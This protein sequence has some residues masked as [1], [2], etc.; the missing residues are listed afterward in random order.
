MM[1]L[2][3]PETKE[4]LVQTG[5]A[6]ASTRRFLSGTL[7]ALFVL[8]SPYYYS[9]IVEKKGTLI[10]KG[11]LRNSD[12]NTPRTIVVVGYFQLS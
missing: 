3:N 5:Q 6:R 1:I 8:G 2:Q 7:F 4:T 10:I 12:K 9:P 11:Q